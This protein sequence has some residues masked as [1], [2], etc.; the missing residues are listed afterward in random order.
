M[1]W[2]RGAFCHLVPDKMAELLVQDG[3]PNAQHLAQK[4]EFE[5][6]GVAF[7]A[8]HKSRFLRRLDP[9]ADLAA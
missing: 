5:A 8:G 1:G 2:G 4:T 9:K 3:V 6:G 7:R